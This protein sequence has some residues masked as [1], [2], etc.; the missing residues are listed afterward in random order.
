MTALSDLL[1]EPEARR[2]AT[3]FSFTEGPL[4][5][6]DGFLYFSE[7]ANWAPLGQL[8]EQ[9][10]PP[11]R[12]WRITPGRSPELVLDSDGGANGI[13]FDFTGRIILCQP[14]ARRVVRLLPEG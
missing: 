1:E 3:G 2:L 6:P 8:R 13:T 11:G 9:A 14:D 12:I 4:W 7:I 10:G 5:H